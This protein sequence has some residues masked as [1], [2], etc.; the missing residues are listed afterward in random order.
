MKK[1]ELPARRKN[2]MTCDYCLSEAFCVAD[3]IRYC[4]KHFPEDLGE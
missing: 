4:V 3:A 2:W 1:E